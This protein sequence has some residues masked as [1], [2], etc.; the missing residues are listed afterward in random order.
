LFSTF[1]T[2]VKSF[3]SQLYGEDDPDQ[4]VSPDTED[5]EAAGLFLFFLRLYY[6]Y[7]RCYIHQ[8]FCEIAMYEIASGILFLP[9]RNTPL[10]MSRI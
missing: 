8:C 3:I 9:P 10:K 4:D 7:I 1:W 2:V 6:P 5:P